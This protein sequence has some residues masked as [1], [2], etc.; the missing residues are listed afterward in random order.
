MNPLMEVRGASFSYNGR[1]NIF[2]GISFS[3][4]RGDI[5]CVL[6]PN[7]TGKTTLVRML[8]EEFDC[9]HESVSFTTRAARANEVPGRDYNFIGTNRLL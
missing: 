3:I 2:E 5:M 9:V 8:C 7:G 1:D 4:E 6:G